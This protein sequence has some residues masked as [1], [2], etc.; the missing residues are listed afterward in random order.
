MLVI[1]LLKFKDMD[2]VTSLSNDLHELCHKVSS[3]GDRLCTR[4]ISLKYVC[5]KALL[6]HEPPSYWFRP[7]CLSVTPTVVMV[8]RSPNTGL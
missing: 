6:G 8:T 5:T 2:A 4:G 7:T 3:L 1:F